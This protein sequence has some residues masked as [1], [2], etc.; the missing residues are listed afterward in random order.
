VTTEMEPQVKQLWVEALRSGR[1]KQGKG[2]LRNTED[3]YCCLGVL[4]DIHDDQ[5][6]KQSYEHSYTYLLEEV[7][8]PLEVQRWSG[9]THNGILTYEEDHNLVHLNDTGSSFEEIADLIEEYL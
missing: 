6:W 7:F 4:C 9:I 5:I 8:V 1:Y 3:E 2:V